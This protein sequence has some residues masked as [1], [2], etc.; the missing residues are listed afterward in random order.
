MS[1]I[2]GTSLLHKYNIIYNI[3]IRILGDRKKN[4]S[5]LFKYKRSLLHAAAANPMDLISSCTSMGDHL[6][7]H[8]EFV[9]E[10]QIG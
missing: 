2:F 8:R 1:S 6:H 4:I 9:D 7:E 5:L 3:H 10:S